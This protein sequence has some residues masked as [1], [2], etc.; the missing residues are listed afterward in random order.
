L[1]RKRRPRKHH[2]GSGP[3]FDTIDETDKRRQENRIILIFCSVCL[4]TLGG[5]VLLISQETAAVVRRYSAPAVESASALHRAA[6][7][8]TVLLTGRID[9]QTPPSYQGFAMYERE[10][11]DP[12]PP[13]WNRY[14]GRLAGEW[15]WGRAGGFHPAFT[16]VTSEGPVH[17]INRGYALE[18]PKCTYEVGDTRYSGFGPDDIV[19]V[20]G[21]SA[22]GGVAATKVFGGKRSE[23]QKT[24]DDQQSLIPAELVVGGVLSGLGALLL[25]VLAAFRMI[26]F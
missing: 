7:G 5:F 24:L 14:G 13:V 3:A 17:I 10:H 26:R 16:L 11:R 15:H 23:F 9:P 20:I 22:E 2:L 12:P 1:N 25:V 19:L 8:Q 21:E 4:L 6:R 18:H